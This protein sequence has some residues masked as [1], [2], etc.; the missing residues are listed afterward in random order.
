MNLTDKERATINKAVAIM[1][2]KLH[3]NASLMFSI[4]KDWFTRTCFD[5]LGRQHAMYDQT[6]NFSAVVDLAIRKEAAVTANPDAERDK[7][8][9]YHRERLAELTEQP[10]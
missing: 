7:T 3:P 6:D 1:Q 9:A 8:I 2:D 5:S 4:R 10:A